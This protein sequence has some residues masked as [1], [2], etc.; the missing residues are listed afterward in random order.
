MDQSTELQSQ[1]YVIKTSEALYE[2]CSFI[3]KKS[4]FEKFMHFC[5][6]TC[7]FTIVCHSSLSCLGTDSKC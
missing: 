5:G 7:I 1:L 4:V 2:N 6:S 3:F